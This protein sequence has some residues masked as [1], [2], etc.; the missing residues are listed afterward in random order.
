MHAPM[1]STPASA[2][3]VYVC[4]MVYLSPRW[5]MCEGIRRS[6]LAHPHAGSPTGASLDG[7]QAGARS[8]SGRHAR[9]AVHEFSSSGFIAGHAAGWVT[10]QR[11]GRFCL[12]KALPG[13]STARM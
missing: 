4:L 7:T 3:T 10:G 9:V 6:R 13:M 12:T 11:L 8:L 2:A 5:N 1:P